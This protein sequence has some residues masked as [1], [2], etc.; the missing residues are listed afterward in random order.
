MDHRRRFE[1]LA[2]LLCLCLLALPGRAPAYPLDGYE[3]TGIGRLL[4]Q[5]LV[6][7]GEIKGRKRP[8]GELLPLSL[9]DLRLLDHPDLELPPPDPKL[10]ARLKKL[11]GPEVDRYG[12][13]LL[14]LSDLANPRYAE[15]HGHQRQN[16]GSVGKLMVALAIFQALADA[17]PDDIEARKRVLRTAMI[18]ADI[19]SVYDHHTVPFWHPETRS[20]TKRPIQKGDTASLWTYI[21]WMMSPSSNSAAGMLQKHLILIA[22]YGKAYPVSPE[23][24]KRFFAET[25]RK[26]LSEIFLKAIEGPITRNGL[27]LEALRQG[28][29]FTHQGK[30]QVPGTSSYATPRALTQYLLKLEQGKLVDEFSSREIKRLMYITE[31]RIRYGSSGVLR[32]SA[33]YFKSG[34]LYSCQPEEEEGFVCKKYHGNKRNY[35]NSVAIIETPA[36]Q[37]R[38]YYM[39][40]VLSNVL[41]KNSAQDHR[42]LARAVHGMLLAQHPE[43]PVPPGAKPP[44]ATYGQGFIGYE[45][46][47]KELA[48]KVDT[49]EALLALGYEIGD[50]DGLIG[51]NTRKAIRTFQQSQG[52]KSDGRPSPALVESMR[53]V[54][55]AKG[56]ARPETPAG[57]NLATGN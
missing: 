30:K 52:M 1:P 55:R 12:I 15:W 9:V 8:S 31:R 37:D 19:F 39:V 16:P 11:I 21:D 10:T 53:R 18:T 54:A 51:S 41:R 33:V 17:H 23:E 38:L 24:E 50:I 28:S 7:E 36:G 46:E 45:A 4:H 40:S 6:Q 14:D 29:F 44:S 49:Q 27:D 56:L 3:S 42:D 13:A 5:R 32:P 48:L 25:P 20:V 2:G 35:M 22:H 34:S 43:K 26:Q 47:R 57:G